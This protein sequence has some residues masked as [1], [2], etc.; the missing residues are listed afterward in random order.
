MYKERVLANQSPVADSEVLEE[1]QIE[2]ERL[3][4]SLRLPS[5]VDNQS[6]NE[7]K[8]AELLSYVERGN[9]DQ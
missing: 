4:L 6:L 3:M 5:G 8:L 9:I 2:S 1:L 7:L